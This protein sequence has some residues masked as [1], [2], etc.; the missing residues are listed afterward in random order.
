MPLE[1]IFMF[2]Q[3][4]KIRPERQ[5]GILS[6]L[7]GL[8]FVCRTPCQYHS[9]STTASSSYYLEFVQNPKKLTWVFGF[10]IGSPQR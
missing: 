7:I 4:N 9:L 1:W 5:N 10:G 6:A 3:S 2:E 8:S